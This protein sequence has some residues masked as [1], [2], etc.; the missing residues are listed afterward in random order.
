MGNSR[1]PAG[2]HPARPQH[3]STLGD[4]NLAPRWGVRSRN[5]CSPSSGAAS[6]CFFPHRLFLLKRS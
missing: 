4:A 1:G 3:P 5:G 2:M 6:S